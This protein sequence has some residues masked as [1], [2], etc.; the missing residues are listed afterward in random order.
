MKITLLFNTGYIACLGG[1]LCAKAQV[2]VE[3]KNRTF[4][5]VVSEIEKQTEFMFFYK[6]EDIDN[7]K[8]VDIQVKNRQVTDV[9]NELLKNTNLTYR[10]S[11]KHITILKKDAVQQTKEKDLR[12]RYG[13][14]WHTGYWGQCCD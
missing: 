7:S 1:Y 13:F 2:T 6:S 10:I 11:G 8:Q 5:D 14:G 12:Y 9:L 3:V 4:Y